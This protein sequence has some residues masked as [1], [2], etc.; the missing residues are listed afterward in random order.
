MT[1]DSELLA[2]FA[3]T[4]SEAAFAELVRRHVSLVYSAAVRQVNGDAH[5]AQDVAQQVFSD[6]AC[7]AGSL[8]RRENLTG[9]L[10]TSAHFAA[11]KIVRAEVRRRTRE[12]QFMGARIHETS[13]EANWE[14][15]GPVLDAAMHE[16]KSTDREAILLRYFE[17][18]PFAEVGAKLGLNE[19]AARMRVDRAV[20]KLRVAFLRRGVP[21][22]TTLAS[23]ISANAVQLAPVNL[24]AALT[25]TSMT[26]AG[27]GTLTFLKFMTATQS[28]FGFGALVIAGAATALVVQTQ[29][30]QHL[31]T[32]NELLRQQM[33]QLQTDNLAFSNQLADADNPKKLRD[34]QLDELLKLRG[35][36]GALRNQA[37][38]FEKMSEE[39]QRLRAGNFSSTQSVPISP[40]DQ[41]K[42]DEWHTVD[43]MKYVGLAM[44]IYSG[45]HQDVLVTNFDQIIATSIY[46]TNRP[47]SIALDGL[48]FM[49][50]G[51]LSY[52]HP[53]LIMFR[54]KNPRQ[55]L[56]GRWVREYGM[57]DGS[58]QTIYSDDGNFN[59]YEK[60]H[61]PPNP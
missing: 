48:E 13:P 2:A 33:A 25:T 37:A 23:V 44:R 34:N 56:D 4:Q 30:Q 41:F 18:H 57:V 27:T 26:A 28:K 46:D 29:K 58:V 36:V 42:L 9:W 16:L 50:A 20:E 47:G 52:D 17:N 5:L 3:R 38:Q 55:T 49:N 59:D 61:S 10:Y 45:D 21:A 1:P 22:T 15:I 14:E 24:A 40:A 8:S 12:E 6:L 31:R 32:E 60:L 53:D 7:K 39:N 54:E 19:N 51:A 35:E 11:A 43:T